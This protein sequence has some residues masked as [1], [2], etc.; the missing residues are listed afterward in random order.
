MPSEYAR[1][2]TS[3][4]LSLNREPDRHWSSID[5][6]QLPEDSPSSGSY[7][8]PDRGGFGP[9]KACWSFGPVRNHQNSF[10]CTHISGVQRLENGNS[11]STRRYNSL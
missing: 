11:L 5:E 8:V 2:F 1:M 10:Y 3:H 9:K 7:P 6:I 4:T